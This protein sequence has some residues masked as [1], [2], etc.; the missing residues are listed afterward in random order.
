MYSFIELHSGALLQ[1]GKY[2]VEHVLGQGGF[3]I[4]YLAE[5]VSLGRAVALKEFFMKD[6]CERDA[7]TSAVSVP[8]QSNRALVEKFKGK[9]N[10][11]KLPKQLQDFLPGDPAG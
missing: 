2:K 11:L 5:Q 4:T 10:N 3:G 7:E 8:T 9:L 1:G 6:C